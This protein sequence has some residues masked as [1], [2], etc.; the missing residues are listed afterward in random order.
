MPESN[1][2]TRVLQQKIM[3]HTISVV[4]ANPGGVATQVGD[5]FECQPLPATNTELLKLLRSLK[6][7]AVLS[8]GEPLCLVERFESLRFEETERQGF[9]LGALSALDFPVVVSVR[10]EE[11]QAVFRRHPAW[12]GLGLRE[13]NERLLRVAK[14]FF[15]NCEVTPGTAEALTLL[16]WGARSLRTDDSSRRIV[17][18]P[19]SEILNG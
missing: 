19:A 17:T 10:R 8:G 14:F 15:R 9:L 4:T 2:E 1:R 12:R 13:F 6:Q 11:W 18:R 16:L 7:A 5:V 3:K